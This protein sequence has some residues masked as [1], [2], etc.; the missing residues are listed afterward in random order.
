MLT[1][2]DL[3]LAESALRGQTVL[4]VYVNGEERDPSKRQ[5]WRLE[6]R[7]A[8]DDI[9]RRLVGSSHAERESF[10]ACRALAEERLR[11]F[12]GTVRA[13]GWVGFFTAAGE[14]S[15]GSLPA[16]TPT[17]AAWSTG[18]SLAPY[19]RVLKEA[20][21]VIVA[22]VDSTSAKI[23]SYANRR[24]VWLETISAHASVDAE[25]HM[26]RPPRAGF[27]AG[28]RGPTEHDRVQVE[29]R[30]AT[31]HMLGDVADQLTDLAG[32]DGWI[33]VGGIPSVASD[34]LKRLG[35]ELLQRAARAES[36]SHTSTLA[37]IAEAAR[38]GA[39]SLRDADD[40][41]RVD[42]VLASSEGD[43]R[44]VVGVVGVL[45]AL[46]GGSVR[47][48]YFTPAFMANDLA[49]TE[50]AVR[51]ALS[52]RALVEQVS[53]AAAE[54]LDQVGGI[55]GRLRYPMTTPETVASGEYSAIR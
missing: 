29:L 47:E 51:K 25:R 55:A 52:T 16:A 23:Y 21:P 40:E 34:A 17:M 30:D 22:V 42:K 12:T 37:E 24:A 33:L 15:S 46:N 43:G 1:N 39:S 8:L 4:T 38:E 26:G 10:A 2:N 27:H 44:G 48:L 7:H 54:R 50:A 53:G 13:P 3:V 31:S 18:P 35:P 45:E 11:E 9:D 5:Q 20:R 36:L 19:V 32:R 14:H 41:R 49:D 6:L 28:T